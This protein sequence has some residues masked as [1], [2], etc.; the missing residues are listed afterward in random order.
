MVDYLFGEIEDLFAFLFE[1]PGCYLLKQN[2]EL[3]FVLD[4]LYS[5]NLETLKGILLGTYTESN[6]F[7]ST[8]R[9]F[10][11]EFISKVAY[12]IGKGMINGEQ[13]LYQ[14]VKQ[15]LID[16]GMMIGAEELQDENYS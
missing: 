12:E 6:T 13:E 8:I 14:R 7:S 11:Y 5:A 4:H 15:N 2:F 3:T 9:K 10:I 1:E 16:F